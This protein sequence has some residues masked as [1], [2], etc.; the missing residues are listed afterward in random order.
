MYIEYFN[1]I[2]SGAPGGSLFLS[3]SFSLIVCGLVYLRFRKTWI[4][5]VKILPFFVIISLVGITVNKSITSKEYKR[6]RKV[7]MNK[8]HSVVQ[9][10]VKDYIPMD[11]FN[12]ESFSVNGVDFF[13]RDDKSNSAFND[14]ALNGG[15]IKEGLN[16]R[17]FYYE[18]S[19]IGL[20][21][22]E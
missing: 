16:V 17:I 15:P 7:L 19:I 12:P 10:I 22:K 14:V 4:K 6:F 13:Y 18:N 9:G 3:I 21:I 1:I 5:M 20:W 2:T 8:E 11:E